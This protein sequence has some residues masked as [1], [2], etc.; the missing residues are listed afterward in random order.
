MLSC[1]GRWRCWWKAPGSIRSLAT[2]ASGGQQVT[3]VYLQRDTQAPAPPQS[4]H[5]SFHSL[6][7]AVLLLLEHL[8]PTF[9][10][11]TSPGEAAG[12][13]QTLVLKKYPD[14]I[15]TASA[16]EW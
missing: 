2:N 6:T 3:E 13:K 16:R 5:S 14:K 7:A 15:V 12:Q 1:L 10:L 8:H 11:Q 9:C 4:V